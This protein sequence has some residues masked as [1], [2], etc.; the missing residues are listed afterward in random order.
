[1]DVEQPPRVAAHEDGAEHPHESSQH[2]QARREGLDF[3][4]SA[5]SK[6]SREG[7]RRCSTTR[8][9][10]TARACELEALCGRDVAESHP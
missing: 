6:A 10:Y 4:S 9:A 8:V 2:D 5:V 1:M 3:P 7:K